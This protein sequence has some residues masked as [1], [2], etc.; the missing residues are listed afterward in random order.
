MHR[1]CECLPPLYF[2]ISIL[3]SISTH[4][5]NRQLA[6]LT[7]KRFGLPNSIIH[8]SLELSRYW[9][10]NSYYSTHP[11]HATSGTTIFNIRDTEQLLKDVVSA[12]V[13]S[14]EIQ[15]THVEIPPKYLPPP[16]FEGSSCVYILQ[17]GDASIARYYVGETDSL[18]RRL[19]EHRSRG[20]EWAAAS[21][22]AIQVKEGK[23]FARKLENIIIR[24]LAKGG[25]HVVS[26]AD[27]TAVRPELS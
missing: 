21:T 22:I 23:S 26:I 19:S 14:V 7:A 24:K 3:H 8:R 10:S 12:S 25:C 5:I 11:E 4:L 1:Q 18:T 27:G 16:S 13:K 20:G 9:D 6:L 2:S 15:P 17:L